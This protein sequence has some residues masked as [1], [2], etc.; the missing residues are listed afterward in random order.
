MSTEFVYFYFVTVSVPLFTRFAKEVVQSPT[1]PGFFD[2]I[3]RA[4][5]WLTQFKGVN[6]NLITQLNV[7]TWL[8]FKL[9]PVL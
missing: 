7:R 4:V 3:V 1:R 2:H 9:R 8:A 5:Q 6:S